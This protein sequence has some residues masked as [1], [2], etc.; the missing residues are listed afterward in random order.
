VGDLLTE[1]ARE[2]PGS[3]VD[4]KNKRQDSRDRDERG[5]PDR[6]M[7]KNHEE[8]LRRTEGRA[9]VRHEKR[10]QGR[11][12]AHLRRLCAWVKKKKTKGGAGNRTPKTL[13]ERPRKN[14][15]GEGQNAPRSFTG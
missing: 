2:G 9:R 12:R 3:K 7:A 10:F 6:P 5:S 13:N 14:G 8:R 15:M 1:R 11:R 4:L